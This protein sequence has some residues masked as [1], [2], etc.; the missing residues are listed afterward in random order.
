VS[1]NKKY[2]FLGALRDLERSPAKRDASPGGELFRSL[3]MTAASFRFYN[4]V[5]IISGEN[6]LDSLGY[7]LK[8]LGAKRPLIITDQGVAAAG[9][10]T[11]VKTALAGAEIAGDILYDRVPPDSSPQIVDQAAGV[12]RERDCDDIISVGGGSVIDTGKAVNIVVTENAA[13]LGQLK[14]VK[15]RKPMQPF[16]V[17]PTTAGTGSEVTYAAMIMDAE[18]KQK[19]LFA[20]YLLFP[21]TAILDPRMTL[22]LPPLTTAATAM[23]AMTHA[24]EA[25]IC[26]PRNPFSNAHSM[27]AIKLIV[28]YLPAVLN[29]P[30]DREARFYLANAACMAGAAF[31]N[32]GVGL[33]HALGHA[34]GGVC[35]V[36]HGVAMNIVL[37]YGLEYNLPAVADII[38]EL[39]LPLA[40]PQRYVET[41][42]GDRPQNT[43][44]A[45]RAI[46]NELYQFTQLPRTLAEAGVAK[47]DFEEIAQKAVKD[48]A[49]SLN[50]L[51][52]SYEDALGI[53]KKAFE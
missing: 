28:N 53:L 25:C 29:N 18:K 4:P 17:I 43:I 35:Q 26:K 24:I 48:P 6:A 12:Y 10:I 19:M 34:L 40:G 51:P 22:S 16:I 37:P 32:S 20:S 38:G 9:L 31:S 13:S 42:A 8:Q 3:K 50:P 49:L 1:E 39:L 47:N 11:L 21:N 7:E 33:I 27:A 52:A 2:F 23:D 46:Q 15:L 44:A 14:G 5:K 45:L 30:A 41:P 36:P